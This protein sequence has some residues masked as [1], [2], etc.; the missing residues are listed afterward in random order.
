MNKPRI[1]HTYKVFMPD[2][3]GG[4]P[5]VIKTLCACTSNRFDNTVLVARKRGFGRSYVIEEG[6]RVEAVGSFD[7]VLSTPVA[8]TYPFRMLRS[9]SRSNLVVHHAPFPL[10]DAAVPF[11]DRKTPLIVYWHADATGFPKLRR[12]VEPAMLRTLRRADRII[13]SDP[14]ILRFSVLQ[15]FSGKCA[16]IPYGLDLAFWARCNEEEQMAAAAIRKRHPRMILAVGR[17]VPYKGL[18]VLLKALPNIDADAVIVGEGP[19]LHRL[20]EQAE[21]FGVSRRVFF[22]GRLNANELKAHFYAARV[23]AFPSITV[24]ETFG[25]VQLEAMAAGLPIVNTDLP[26]GVPN[27]ARNR[28]EALTVTPNAPTELATA[29]SSILNDASLAADLGKAGRSRVL[30]EYSQSTYRTR[31]ES[32]YDELVKG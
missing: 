9:A 26:T 24:A 4:I 10:A 29:L 15:P 31:I 23:F 30:A 7:T 27:V 6:V 17:L 18:E 12:V 32:L 11:L 5:S 3:D 1:L 28:R 16:V 2:L 13:I 20:Q 14:S 25:I 22:K 8:P 19:L 21:R